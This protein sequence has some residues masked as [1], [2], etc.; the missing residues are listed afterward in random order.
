MNHIP[1]VAGPAWTE[2]PLHHRWLTAESERLLVFFEGAVADERGGFSWLRADG[3]PDRDRPQDLYACARLV[4]CFALAH[5]MGRP[6]ARDLALHGMSALSGAFHDDEHGGWFAAV[7]PDA[8]P[9]DT[10]K[11]AYAHAFVLLAGATATQA[12]LPG[13][14][15]LL[16]EAAATIDRHFWREE[17]GAALDSYDR[18]W[19][20]PEDYRGQNSN[21]HLT[22]A[23]LAAAE[24]TGDARFGERALRISDLIIRKHGAA[25]EWRVPEHFDTDWRPDLA[26]NSDRPEDPFRPCGSLVGHWL[27][28]ARLLVMVRAQTSGAQAAWTT[29]AARQLFAR[30]VAEGWDAERGGFVYSVDFA[31]K[32]VNRQRMH[33]TIAEAVGAAVFLYRATGDATYEGWYR[34]F[35][36]YAARDVLDRAG[37]SWW[38][39]LD[40]DGHPTTTTWDGKPDLYHAFQATLYPRAPQH[41]GLG[42]AARQGVIAC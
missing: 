32:P 27:E 13:G 31:G 17:E 29:Q 22:E 33:W 42:E 24:A 1:R 18:T 34:S 3:T 25:H 40:T 8:T 6:G 35:W 9:A 39:E 21:M 37:G 26:Y 16:D 15:A 19:T 12:G 36:D 28:W 5:L 20:T 23:Y 14:R 4:H 7:H 11:A 10:T 2:S 30:A 38:H 41:L